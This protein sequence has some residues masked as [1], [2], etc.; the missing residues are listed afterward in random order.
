MAALS[1]ILCLLAVVQGLKLSLD[2]NQDIQTQL[3]IIAKQLSPSTKIVEIHLQPGSILI[4][5]QLHLDS[6]PVNVAVSLIG[7]PTAPSIISGGVNISD[8][9][10]S[11][12]FPEAFEA[13]VPTSSPFYNGSAWLP[14]RQLY[15][16]G[17]RY[18][19]T[20]TESSAIGLDPLSS[21]YKITSSGYELV[22]TLPQHWPSPQSVE[23]VSDHTWVQHR[24]PVAEVQV[25]STSL[26]PP[27]CNWTS[28][29]AGSSPGTAT[30]TSADSWEDCQAHC[31]SNA[32]W[33]Q[34]II[35]RPPSTC[36]LAPRP[37]QPNYQPTQGAYVADLLNHSLPAPT[38]R[39]VMAQ[40]CFDQAQAGRY[41]MNIPSFIENTGNL[42]Q[43]GQFWFDRSIG[44]V[45]IRPNNV[46]VS[47]AVVTAGQ[48]ESLLNVSGRD[49]VRLENVTF[50]YSS[51][52]R[53]SSH[54][55]YVERYGTVYFEP[56]HTLAF[57]P[58]AVNVYNSHNVTVAG[59][60]F[61]HL[62]AWGLAIGQG[63][64]HITVEDSLFE[65]LSAG[66]IVMG[67]VA[68]TA[69]ADPARQTAALK[70]E[71]NRIRHVGQE[72]KGSPGVHVFCIRD[73]VFQHNE[74][75]FVPYSGISYNWPLKQGPTLG[76][77]SNSTEL[78]YSAN[79]Y[80]A[81]NDV[82]NYMSYMFDGAGIH[83]I[84]RSINTTLNGNY[85]H[86]AGSGQPGRHSVE[87]ESVIYIDNWSC[88]FQI[89]NTVID[90]T[91]FTKQGYTFFQGNKLGPAHDNYVDTLYLRNASSAGPG[92][93]LPCNCTHVTDVK[94]EWPPAAQDIIGNAG[95]RS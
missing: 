38:T 5:K 26:A 59:C 50:A 89:N 13:Q 72:Y 3:D 36:Y 45:Y 41:A 70:I 37:F 18:N 68:D 15:V 56:N 62:G 25:V 54:L 32:S 85:F 78:G 20:R 34:S 12:R 35:F 8:F 1:W 48:T 46:D 80:I 74:I 81:F 52:N 69:E 21:S 40:P 42:S 82:S 39:V 88:D 9:T 91:P 33:C 79:N 90:N 94:G 24:C 83:T 51:W 86:D 92:A 44:K 87:C 76:P 11:S 30:M 17:I 16:N 28:K 60:T 84:G 73:S 22:S 67:D 27:S 55:G 77:E 71:D 93:G 75:A 57:P 23:F 29:I 95:P 66:S 4:S 63:S 2:A 65:D 58:A 6:F 53:P 19:R 43:P 49:N 47:S 10:P 31:C 14:L 64:Q 7:S 61:H